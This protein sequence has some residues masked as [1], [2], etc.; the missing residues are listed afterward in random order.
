MRVWASLIL[1]LCSR[2]ALATPTELK[3]GNPV[4]GT[5]APGAVVEYVATARRSCGW[6]VP[7]APSWGR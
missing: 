3:P 6:S 2:A 1:L 7:P 4:A 5:L